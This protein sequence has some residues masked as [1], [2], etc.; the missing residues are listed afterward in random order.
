M[1]MTILAQDLRYAARM[2]RK[3]PGFTA[4]AVLTLAIGIAADTTLFSVVNG[5]LLNPLPYPHPEQVTAV[6]S[7]TPGV[8]RGPSTYPNFQDWQRDTRTF[9]SL[10]M[11]RNQDYSVIGSSES[12]RLTGYQIS[13]D[14]FA[15]LGVNPV[16]GRTFRAQDDRLGAGPVVLLGGGLWTR[17]FGASPNVI[18][19]ALLL[20]GTAY[21][22][23]G[24]VPA[25]FRFYGR[26]RDVYTPIGQW[27][28]PS[29]LDRRI[30]VSARV[31]GRLKPGV[32]LAQAQADMDVMARN[33]A[34]AF[35]VADRQVGITLVS[36]KD[37]IVGNVQPFLL[38]LLAAV[39]FLLLIACANVANL[40]LARA[41]GRTREFAIRSAL[42]AS[43]S[44]VV[45][46]LL[47]ESVLLAG[48]GGA[49]GLAL[50]E[51][52]TKAA[53][54]I[55]PNAVPRAGEVSLDSRVLIF[56]LAISLLAGI[57]FGLAP[58]MK[59]SRVDLQDV[60]RS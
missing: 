41:L 26:D 10:A 6:Y 37:D 3:S 30:S 23:V 53:L 35:P 21:T 48:A 38:V 22:I 49:L 20:N 52:G 24:V 8:D 19:Q 33:L 34:K 4:I 39:G 11:Y 17:K 44:R 56:T 18:G 59:G 14:F 32:T 42:G 36:M 45:R 13:A 43:P 31:I 29:F 40:L 46:Q 47:T 27:G 15:T 58:A 28:D 9:S 12:E 50:A 25:S 7:S 51:F 1:P 5:V 60:L 2:A 57:F 16:L 54:E 55:L